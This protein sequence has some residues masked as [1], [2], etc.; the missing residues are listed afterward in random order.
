LTTHPFSGEGLSHG[1]DRASHPTCSGKQQTACY[2]YRLRKWHP[3]S[4]AL[5]AFASADM[6]YQAL[7]IWSSRSAPSSYRSPSSR[8]FTLGP[9]LLTQRSS[10][11]C[12]WSSR[13]RSEGGVASEQRPGATVTVK[14]PNPVPSARPGT[15]ISETNT[16]YN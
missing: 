12:K 13:S 2:F 15:L 3:S 14:N 6:R 7:Q 5:F 9:S 16:P 1:S 8:S 10:A 4:L 11:A